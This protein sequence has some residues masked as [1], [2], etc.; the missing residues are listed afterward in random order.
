MFPG[1]EKDTIRQQLSESLVGVVWQQLLK[2][3]D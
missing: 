2:T 3:K 1:D